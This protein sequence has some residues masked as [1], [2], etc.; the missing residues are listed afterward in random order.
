M[1]YKDYLRSDSMNL[2]LGQVLRSSP[3]VLLGVGPD[4]AH[5][6]RTLGINTVFDLA[7][8]STFGAA[9]T[10]VRGVTGDSAFG[11]GQ[12]PGG[13]VHHSPGRI[14]RERSH[15]GR[16]QPATGGGGG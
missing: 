10:V 5:S 6:L 14:D 2:E 8:S 3:D 16:Q 15:T 11:S 12:L 9:T 13:P 4:A 1:A 7:G